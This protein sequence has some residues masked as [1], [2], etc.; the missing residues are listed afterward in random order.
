M[1]PISGGWASQVVRF[2]GLKDGEG[3]DPNL[4]PGAKLTL[5]Y[6]NPGGRK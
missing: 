5:S 3:L 6:A 4:M 2:E 1:C